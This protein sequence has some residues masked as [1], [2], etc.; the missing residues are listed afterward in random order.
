MV[1]MVLGMAKANRAKASAK[2]LL[3][4][5]AMLMVAWAL[6]VAKAATRLAKQRAMAIAMTMV[7]SKA[8]LIISRAMSWELAMAV[9][10]KLAMMAKAISTPHVKHWLRLVEWSMGP[11]Q[12]LIAK[13]LV[14]GALV[15]MS[16]LVLQALLWVK[17]CQFS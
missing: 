1:A 17:R 10:Y 8:Q 6:P 9:G 16:H 13:C 3:P 14:K 15:L 5:W 7:V 11:L 12:R 2:V 4:Q